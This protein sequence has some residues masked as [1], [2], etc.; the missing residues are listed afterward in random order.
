[1]SVTVGKRE[2]GKC[3]VPSFSPSATKLPLSGEKEEEEKVNFCFRKEERKV[4]TVEHRH[5]KLCYLVKKNKLIGYTRQSPLRTVLSHSFARSRGQIGNRNDSSDLR[6]VYADTFKSRMTGCKLLDIRGDIK[7]QTSAW[8]GGCASR[9]QC[10]LSYAF[11]S[12]CSAHKQSTRACAPV[13]AACGNHLKFKSCSLIAK[14]KV[15]WLLAPL[16]NS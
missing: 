10:C 12:T 5:D 3:G 4:G 15:F 8:I 13:G 7:G 6:K 2:R 1:M 16:P 9:D 14:K 11:F